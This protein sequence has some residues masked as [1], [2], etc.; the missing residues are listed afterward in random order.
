LVAGAGASI[1][2]FASFSTI[3]STTG[4][5]TGA[6][7]ATGADAVVVG[8]LTSPGVGVAGAGPFTTGVGLTPVDSFPLPV[9]SAVRD[10]LL[11]GGA[12]LSDPVKWKG[13][14]WSGLEGHTRAG[15]HRGEDAFNEASLACLPVLATHNASIPG[16]K[17]AMSFALWHGHH[18][19]VKRNGPELLL[20]IA[21]I[22]LRMR[23]LATRLYIN[24]FTTRAETAFTTYS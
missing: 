22:E 2:D 13:R 10:G 5:V 24:W 19:L 4:V 1:L 11:A 21:V 20:R 14:P 23:W 16:C 8:A 3:F 18:V 6:G 17:G 7:V 9:R 12:P 15:P